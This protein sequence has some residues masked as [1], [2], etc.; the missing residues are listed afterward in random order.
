MFDIGFPAPA[1]WPFAQSEAYAC[2]ARCLGARVIRADLGCGTALVVERWGL[3]LMSRGPVW[4]SG[5]EA[6][7]R[8]ALRR[9]AYR[10][11][12]TVATPEA[13]L[14]GFG[15][16][17]LVTPAHHAIW[18]IGAEVTA[19]RAGLAGK[20]RNRLVAAER[21]GL[22]VQRGAGRDWAGLIA[23][24]AGQRAVR[25]YRALPPA[26]SDALPQDVRRIWVWRQGG[27]VR[28]AMGFVVEGA[29]ATYH[30]GWADATA[31]AAGAHRVMLWQAMCALRSEGARWIDLGLVNDEAAPGLARFKLGTGAALRRLGATML[32][33]PG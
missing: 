9:F 21:I 25:G 8:A 11:G 12:V 27:Q 17:P 14:A 13:G 10:F 1:F 3:R 5:T 29:T 24:E 6:E 20:W 23:A 7:R 33:L 31:R 15:L 32:V 22:R 16:I 26:F 28:A 30:L 18:D 19:L 4:T 2:A